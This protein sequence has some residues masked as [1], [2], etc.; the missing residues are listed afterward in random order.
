VHRKA[1]D[2]VA[3][4]AAP[5]E[6]SAAARIVDDDARE[7]SAGQMRKSDFLSALRRALCQTVDEALKGTSRSTDGCP[8]IE[9]LFA[10]YASQS[11]SDVEAAVRRYVPKAASVQSAAGYI[12]LIVARVG[13]AAAVWAKTGQITGLPEGFSAGSA[14]GQTAEKPAAAPEQ[15]SFKTRDG[16]QAPAT[17][18]TAVRS[19]LGGGSPMESGVRSRMESAFGM[20]FSAV[21][22]HTDAAGANLSDRL[23]ARAFT[24]GSD[25]AFAS[26]EYR[27]GTP[28]GDAL[29]AHEL[30]HV[31]QQGHAA[32]A[33]MP[34]AGSGPEASLESDADR[35]ALGATLSLWDRAR[36]GIGGIAGRILPRLKSGLQVQRCRR[37]VKKCPP[38]KHWGV[39]GEGLG[40]GSVGC[41][42]VWKCLSGA[43]PKA[44]YVPPAQ[45]TISCPPDVYCE[46]PPPVEVVGDDYQKV[47]KGQEQAPSQVIGYGAHM[48]PMTGAKVCGCLPLDI[49]GGESTSSALVPTGF[50]PTDLYTGPM[51]G[52]GHAPGVPETRGLEPEAI[53]ETV[54]TETE[55]REPVREALGERVNEPATVSTAPP[56]PALERLGE[57]NQE[58]SGSPELKQWEDQIEKLRTT[59]PPKAEQEAASLVRTAQAAR[60]NAARAA[61]QTGGDDPIFTLGVGK[62]RAARIQSGEQNFVVDRRMTFDVDEVLPVGAPD[63]KP[64]RAVGRATSAENRQLLDP[65]TNQRTKGLGTD[66]RELPQNRTAREP[67]SVTTD[68]HALLTR[69]FSEVH[70]LQR[71]FDRAVASV[72]EPQRLTPTQLKARINAETRR[73]ITE[74]PGP[75]A[76]AVRKALGDLGFERQPGVGWVMTKGPAQ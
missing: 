16:A 21:R 50:D 42:C 19:Q 67:V 4:Q 66:P 58:I 51:P 40:L 25:I 28:W 13:R 33:A 53:R 46:G 60:N 30:A 52:G 15:V 75:D 35:A 18:A 54:H 22:V 74:D 71:I 62:D 45:D 70:E 63:I 29:M 39:V 1:D 68:P 14:T 32:P 44:D 57:Y 31:V 38:N 36:S 34:E 2:T 59:D 8:W 72:T 61:G 65:N 48:T 24:V 5:E 20:D 17:D 7:L 47:E 41:V 23:S 6:K 55:A 3:L 12:S 56:K 76:A 73:I 10:A 26:G 37:S 27:P 64:Q 69:R 43:P 49:E 9:R 11:G